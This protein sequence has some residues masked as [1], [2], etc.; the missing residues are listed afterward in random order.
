MP[1][2][3]IKNPNAIIL[4]VSAANTDLATS[5][6]IQLAKRVRCLPPT[7][8]LPPPAPLPP[9][10]ARAQPSAPHQVDPAG[11]RTM[12]VLTKPHSGAQT[13][14]GADPVGRRALHASLE[15]QSRR[16]PLLL[17]TPEPS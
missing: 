8:P 12:G 17:R 10:L 6:A 15:R 13:A 4:A 1:S 9:P 11:E 14:P 3:Y 5:D 2:Q 16:R 7:P